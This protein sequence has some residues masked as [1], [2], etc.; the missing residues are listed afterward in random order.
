M[1]DYKSVMEAIGSCLHVDWQ[2]TPMQEPRIESFPQDFSLFSCS[3]DHLISFYPL[4]LIAWIL[5]N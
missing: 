4:G 2:D 5:F 3:S 1:Q